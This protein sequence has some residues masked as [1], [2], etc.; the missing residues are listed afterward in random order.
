M[1]EPIPLMSWFTSFIEYAA[2]FYLVLIMFFL[3]LKH[4]RK[5]D[6]VIP[7]FAIFLIGISL[8]RLMAWGRNIVTEDRAFH[9]L[10][11]ILGVVIMYYIYHVICQDCVKKK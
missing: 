9:Y 3:S 2:L 11:F 4:F 1:N 7:A 8:F 10:T 5:Y 6:V